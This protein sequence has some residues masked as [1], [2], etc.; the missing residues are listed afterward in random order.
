MTNQDQSQSQLYREFLLEHYQNP[1]NTG[2]PDS[3]SHSH[4]LVN[5]SCGDEIT[6]YVSFTNGKVN[7]IHYEISG[8]ALSI[9][10]SSIL[11]QE[12]V[13]K[14]LDEVKILNENFL[15]EL[16]HTKL[17]INRVKC[18]LL[19]LRAIQQAIGAADKS[20]NIV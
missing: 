18:A 5:R 6:V 19:P 10:T 8:C 12:L 16:L 15:E 9:A 20:D 3:Y 7:D 17:S 13:G 4:T 1:A 11:S 2:K 14:S